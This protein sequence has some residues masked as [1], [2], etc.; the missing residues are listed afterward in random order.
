MVNFVFSK[1]HFWIWGK[2]GLVLL[3]AVLVY[4]GTISIALA[5]G[6]EVTTIQDENDHSCSDG[7]CSLRDAIEIAAAG[8]TVT[9]AAGLSGQTIT[10]T[11]GQVEINKMLSITGTVPITISGNNAGRIFYIGS[12]GR[13]TLSDLRIIDGVMNGAG[14]DGDGGGIYSLGWLTMTNSILTGNSAADDGGAIYNYGRDLILDSST[15]A[16]NSAGS[17]GSVYN[18]G[19]SVVIRNNDLSGNSASWGGAV[20]SLLGSMEI[21]N[22]QVAGNSASW[23]GGLYNWGGEVRVTD[24]VVINNVA[25]FSGGGMSNRDELTVRGTFF[26]NNTAGDGAGIYNYGNQ[27][28]I[29]NSTLVGNLDG[30]GISNE[31]VLTV[32]NCTIADNSSDGVFNQ[33]GGTLHLQNSIIANS[34]GGDDCKNEGYIATNNHNLME[35]SSCSPAFSG[36]PGLAPLGDYGGPSAGVGA[37]QTIKTHALLNSSPAIDAGDNSACP[38]SDQ[39]G[40]FRPYDGDDNGS[41]VCDLG[42]YEWNSEVILSTY[43]PVVLK[44]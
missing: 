39:R 18:Y 12:S 7:D 5:A 34:H 20:Y 15:L 22:S 38:A 14:A 16:G 27:A 35:D 36:D 44:P 41:A 4:A 8:E 11:A 10:L 1:K 37:G 9:F 23:G 21:D 30:N 28:T 2:F 13:V 29:E 25:Y 3:L 32:L 40:V 42:A 24:S 33:S 6:P 31:G 26:S 43:L 17:G 19:G